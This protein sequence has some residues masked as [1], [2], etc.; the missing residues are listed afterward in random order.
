MSR[1]FYSLD[2]SDKTHDGSCNRRARS[3]GLAARSIPSVA[4]ACKA[5]KSGTFYSGRWRRLNKQY[6]HTVSDICRFRKLAMSIFEACPSERRLPLVTTYMT[7]IMAMNMGKSRA[8]SV[9]NGMCFFYQR[10]R[11]ESAITIKDMLFDETV[12]VK[13]KK[14]A[15]KLRI[16][17]S[18][19]KRMSFES[20][21]RSNGSKKN[22]P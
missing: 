6:K 8:E 7:N 15:S 9:E 3:A 4:G 12:C 17:G 19:V 13:N 1:I 10:L 5:K 20:G 11:G 16:L 2:E 22:C 21:H 14:H 18:S